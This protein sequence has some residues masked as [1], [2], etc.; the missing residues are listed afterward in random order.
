[1]KTSDIVSSG[2]NNPLMNSKTFD[3]VSIPKEQITSL[4]FPKSDVLWSADEIAQRKYDA[5]KGLLL[6]NDF[7]IKVRIIF[8]D[9]ES[10]KQV[11]TTIWGLT[12]EHLILKKGVVIPLHRIHSIIVCP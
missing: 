11:E 9:A 7:K 12:E 4:H 6:G 2:T 1:M 10:T 8:E 3:P 5:Q